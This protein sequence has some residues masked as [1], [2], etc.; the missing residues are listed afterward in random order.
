VIFNSID[1]KQK[2]FI[3]GNKDSI[4]NIGQAKKE[5]IIFIVDSDFPKENLLRELVQYFDIKI[6][7]ADE[8]DECPEFKSNFIIIYNVLTQTDFFSKYQNV[9]KNFDSKKVVI[10]TTTED[11]LFLKRC[12]K[13]KNVLDVF[14]IPFNSLEVSIKIF[15]KI[16]DSNN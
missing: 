5:K 10:F 9:I 6:V 15:C 11:P 16:S 12:L 7:S 3:V 13:F 4:L 2:L 14:L 8:L 1:Y